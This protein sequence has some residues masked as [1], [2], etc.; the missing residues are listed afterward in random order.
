MRKK[1]LR[2]LA[3]IFGLA[4]VAGVIYYHLPPSARNQPTVVSYKESRDL[5]EILSIFKDDWYWLIASKPEYDQA[6]I[7]F[8]LKNRTPSKET[9]QYYGSLEIKTLYQN[10]QFIGFTAY[11]MKN[12]YTGQ[13]LFIAL[14]PEFKGKGFARYLM[15]YAINALKSKGA[16][17]INLLT[18]TTNEPAQKLYRRFGFKESYQED[19]FVYFTLHLNGQ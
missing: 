16:K 7:E 17:I 8:L 15:E 14:K 19:G 2:I 13:L 10:N 11:Y 4:L 5:S 12:F 9:P 3:L 18:R 1:Q 6:F